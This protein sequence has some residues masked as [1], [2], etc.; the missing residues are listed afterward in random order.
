MRDPP[1]LIDPAQAPFAE[2]LV[3]PFA[4]HLRVVLS[5][6]FNLAGV[7]CKVT[8]NPVDEAIATRESAARIETSIDIELLA[9]PIIGS[10]SPAP[11]H[12]LMTVRT[13]LN[14]MFS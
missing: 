10:G 1:L 9:P 14:T 5:P 13:F 7:A 3:A 2:Q 4:A 6:T 12:R 8:S 11:A